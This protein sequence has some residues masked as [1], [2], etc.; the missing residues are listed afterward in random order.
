MVSIVGRRIL[1]ASSLKGRLDSYF[2]SLLK[3]NNKWDNK[4]N[5]YHVATN[6]RRLEEYDASNF[7]SLAT[8]DLEEQEDVQPLDSN[9][10]HVLNN[11]SRNRNGMNSII[12]D[13]QN[14]RPF[15]ISRQ[16]FV[17]NGN[18]TSAIS[19]LE[20]LRQRLKFDDGSKFLRKN[21]V[22]N[23]FNANG[24]ANDA[25]SS[26]KVS[27]ST[28]DNSS[29]SSS[30]SWEQLLNQAKHHFQQHDS[31]TNL[32]LNSHTDIINANNIDA[33]PNMLVDSYSR[34]HSYLRISLS[35]RCNLRCQYCMPPE[36]VPLQPKDSLLS[37]DEILRLTN[38]FAQSGV[39]KVRLTGGEPTLRK[40]LPDIIS[41]IS[42]IPTIQSVGITT[43][44]LTLSRNMSSLKEAGLTHVNISLD[45]LQHS[46]FEE[47]TRRKGLSRVLAAIEDASNTFPH[48]NVKVNCVVMKNFNEHEL[49]DFVMI[50]E[51]LP[52]DVRFIEWMPFSDNG[53]SKNRFFS[54]KDMMYNI[55]RDESSV[56][57][58]NNDHHPQQQ[59]QHQHEHENI[60]PPLELLRCQDGPNDTTKWW[61]VSGHLGRVGFITSMSQHFCGTC[62]RLRITADGKLKVCLF[63]STEVSLRDAMRSGLS[64]DDLGLIVKASVMQKNFSLGGHGNAEGI[65]KANDNRPMTLIGG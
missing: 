12:N 62:N 49:R 5:H 30:S 50:T 41:S 63:G 48:G 43:N 20:E 6:F 56:F 7:S 31:N 58:N 15:P 52:V 19:R 13:G 45:T 10:I 44:G 9:S 65:A 42:S 35:E 36:G 2:L 8:M 23:D 61:K 28:S 38:L 46:K 53:W 11:S 55:T 29:S 14:K 24:A 18:E 1:P 21:A 40:D 54:Y 57:S 16:R 17:K 3:K 60:V 27:L 47:I 33:N 22:E 59:Q 25:S 34:H 64:D 39:D 37:H 4:R 51:H 26:G 32:K